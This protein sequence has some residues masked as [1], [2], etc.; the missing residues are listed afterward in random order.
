[1]TKWYYIA[2]NSLRLIT[3]NFDIDIDNVHFEQDYVMAVGGME[4]YVIFKNQKALNEYKSRFIDSFMY[5]N[6]SNPIILDN[7]YIAFLIEF[8]D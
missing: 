5:I 7:E 4:H 8:E 1:M 3:K 6:L 2:E